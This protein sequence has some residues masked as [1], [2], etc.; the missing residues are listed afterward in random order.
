[1]AWRRGS[2]IESGG[3]V[4][5]GEKSGQYH[6]ASAAA[7]S[8]SISGEMASASISMAT[9]AGDYRRHQ[10]GISISAA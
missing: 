9:T 4:K 2:S 6:Q 10:R 3:G 7:S 5:I 8:I 1:V